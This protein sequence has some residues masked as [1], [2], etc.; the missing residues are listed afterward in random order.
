MFRENRKQGS[1]PLLGVLLCVCL[2][3]LLCASSLRA[4]PVYSGDMTAAS[5]EDKAGVLDSPEIDSLLQQAVSLAEKTGM[6][7]RVVT[8]DDAEGKRTSSYAE[9]YFESLSDSFKGG[10]YLLDLDNREFYVATYGDLQYYLTDDRIG[11]MISNAGNYA[12]SGDWEG[13]LSSMMRDTM[14]YIN[15]GVQDGTAIYDEDTGTYTYYE[16][17]KRIT[18]FEGLMSGGVGLLGFLSVFFSTKRR[19]EMKNPEKNDY[20]FTDNVK[21]RLSANQDRLIDRRVHRRLIPRDNDGGGGHG[22][23]GIHIST[24]HHTSGGHSAGGGGGHF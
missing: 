23:G 5:V 3:V 24:V 8:T 6:E 22:G 17:P 1:V 14:S 10:C 4:D 13:T 18:L 16:P 7:F 2:A 19:Y 20:S 12:R 9:D 15:A 21:M 11:R